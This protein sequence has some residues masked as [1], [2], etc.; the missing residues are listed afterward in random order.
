LPSREREKK[1]SMEKK[2]NGEERQRKG[3]KSQEMPRVEAEFEYNQAGRYDGSS[4]V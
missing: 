2:R 1:M 3:K 4:Q